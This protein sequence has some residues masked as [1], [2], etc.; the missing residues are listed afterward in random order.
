MERGIRSR[1]NRS[2]GVLPPERALPQ[3]VGRSDDDGRQAWDAGL[4]AQR[5]EVIAEAIERL[6]LRARRRAGQEQQ[7]SHDG[8]QRTGHVAVI[9]PKSCPDDS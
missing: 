3:N 7:G 9:R 4:D 2:L 6:I 8:E 5:L 1:R